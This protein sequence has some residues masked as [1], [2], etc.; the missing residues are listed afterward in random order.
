M[1]FG[2]V[3]SSHEGLDS[4]GEHDLNKQTAKKALLNIQ[5]R[6]KFTDK[7]NYE[8]DITQRSRQ[9]GRL[10]VETKHLISPQA[11][12]NV[13]GWGTLQCMQEKCVCNEGAQTNKM[14][15]ELQC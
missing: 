12:G 10:A 7:K 9:G 3:Q 13:I 4:D 1:K 15:A 8:G 6:S 14:L 2:M 11:R 5:L